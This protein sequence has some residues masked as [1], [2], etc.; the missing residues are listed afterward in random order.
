MHRHD[1]GAAAGAGKHVGVGVIED[2]HHVGAPGLAPQASGIKEV[3]RHVPL[4][5][6]QGAGQHDSGGIHRL[7]PP[8]D[9]SARAAPVAR[10]A[11]QL[12]DVGGEPDL[13]A[14]IRALEPVVQAMGILVHRGPVFQRQVGN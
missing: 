9:E 10:L 6:E 2:V 11:R 12:P 8:A 4:G 1:H 14:R 3:A 5:A 13:H 7:A